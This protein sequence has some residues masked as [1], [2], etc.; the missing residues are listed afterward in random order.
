LTLYV[1]ITTIGESTI[2]KDTVSVK[3][4]EKSMWSPELSEVFPLKH[5]NSSNVNRILTRLVRQEVVRSHSKLS[6]CLT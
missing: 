2:N 1:L 6:A 4:K 5:S 3:H